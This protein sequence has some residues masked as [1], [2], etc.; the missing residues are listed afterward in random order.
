MVNIFFPQINMKHAFK[1][2]GATENMNR[3]RAG[4]IDGSS[5]FYFQLVPW[6]SGHK[7]QVWY[8]LSVQIINNSLLTFCNHS[9]QNNI[10]CCIMTSLTILQVLTENTHSNIT[11][12][13]KM[14]FY[15]N[16]LNK[17]LQNLT[18]LI[19]RANSKHD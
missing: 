16:Y 4:C 17:V 19:F 7:T 11:T 2:K 5:I 14:S 8:W 6:A 18:N 10:L 12:W 13:Y 9:P 3:T 15:S 1:G